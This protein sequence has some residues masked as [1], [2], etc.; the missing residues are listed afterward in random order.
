VFATIPEHNSDKRIVLFSTA[1][2]VKSKG[3]M[4]PMLTFI[5][6]EF[7]TIASYLGQGLPSSVYHTGFPT[8]TFHI[9]FL[10]ALHATCLFHRVLLDLICLMIF[11][12]DKNY[13]IHHFA[14]FFHS[15]F[16]LSL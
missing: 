14:T 2:S 1:Y 3:R 11:G 12:H 4:T 16:A 5:S 10:S 15:P 8:K 7:Q 13:E 9:I 6:I